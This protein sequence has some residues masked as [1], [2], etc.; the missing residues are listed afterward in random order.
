MTTPRPKARASEAGSRR[1][2][3]AVATRSAILEAAT[4]QFATLGYEHAGVR[5]IAAAAGVTAALVNR[6]FG[7][8][9]ALFTEVVAG[10]CDI[11]PW[12]HSAR[13][14]LPG[15]LARLMVFGKEGRG[16]D[17]TPFLLWLRTVTEPRAADLFRESV[18]RQNLRA[19]AA[20]IGGPDADLRA[21][22]VIGQIIGFATLE[23]LLRPPGL[24]AADRQRLVALLEKSLAACIDD[25]RPV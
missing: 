16:N 22:L 5:E 13:A 8:K 15:K 14:D 24:V 25:D 12:V 18:E 6:Y 9:E 7:S 3:D 10:A 20:I 11:R 23:K 21:A 1:R 4:A 2:R 19:L 17:H